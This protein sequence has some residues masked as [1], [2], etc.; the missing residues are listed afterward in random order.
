LPGGLLALAATLA[1]IAT[2]KAD[3]A[4]CTRFFGP[5]YRDYMQRTGPAG[6]GG[7]QPLNDARR[8]LRCGYGA[9]DRVRSRALSH[10]IVITMSDRPVTSAPR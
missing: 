6:V 8:H 7:R 1:L 5:A 9:L 10:L 4:E 2:A 3:E